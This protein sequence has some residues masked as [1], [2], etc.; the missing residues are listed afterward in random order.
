MLCLAS[1]LNK[2]LCVR[3]N[4][5][6]KADA[7]KIAVAKRYAPKLKVMFCSEETA[8]KNVKSLHGYSTHHA[9]ERVQYSRV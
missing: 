5:F 1:S 8:C 6:S 2:A 4:I 3:D 9:R 7:H